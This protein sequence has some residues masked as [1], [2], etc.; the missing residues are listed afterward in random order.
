MIQLLDQFNSIFGIF[1]K[2]VSVD[3]ANLATIVSNLADAARD[4]PGSMETYPR[5][6]HAIN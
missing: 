3:A 1:G 2:L 5:P 4:Y 6:I